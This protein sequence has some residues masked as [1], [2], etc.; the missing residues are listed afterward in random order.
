M[1]ELTNLT[2]QTLQP[3][4]SLVFDEVINHFGCCECHRRN[5]PSVKLRSRGVY[6]I[7]F[8]GNI[9]GATADAPAQLAISLGGAVLP[10]TTMISAAT[11]VN[12]VSTTTT[13]GGCCGGY[14]MVTVTNNGTVPVTVSPNTAF[15]IHKFQN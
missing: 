1:I 10:E 5:S 11:G 8:S 6:E 7:H 14:D 9:D 3:G 2:A 13:V 12:N 4:Q 15:V